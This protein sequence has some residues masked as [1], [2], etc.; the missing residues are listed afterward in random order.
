MCIHDLLDEGD[1]EDDETHDWVHAVNRGGL[2][3]VNNATYDF[4]GAVEGEIRKLLNEGKDVE[5]VKANIGVSDN[6]AFFW[7]R[8]CGDTALLQMM[9]NQYVKIRGFPMPE[10]K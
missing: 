9:V 4:L 8:V 5:L 6:V 7:S 1:E 2:T 3:L 10:I